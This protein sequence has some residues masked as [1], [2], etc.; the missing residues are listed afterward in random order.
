MD[1][2]CKVTM[3]Y[4]LWI[5]MGPGCYGTYFHF[6]GFIMLGKVSSSPDME[7]LYRSL[8][9]REVHG[10]FQNYIACGDFDVV[11]LFISFVD[12]GGT[13]HSDLIYQTSVYC[14]QCYLNGGSY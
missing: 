8:G 2:F 10:Q 5:K 6:G 11:Q 13:L 14:N 4:D 12:A 7:S 1:A 9:K 3:T